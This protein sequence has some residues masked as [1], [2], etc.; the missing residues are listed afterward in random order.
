MADMRLR[1]VGLVVSAL[2]LTFGRDM[3][4]V[5]AVTIDWV[6]VGDPGNAAVSFGASKPATHRRVKPATR[7]GVLDGRILFFGLAC[8][9]AGSVRSG[10]IGRIGG[11]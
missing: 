7:W 8:K 6:D 4:H 11:R 2:V 3:P 10:G 5:Q 1:I 9:G